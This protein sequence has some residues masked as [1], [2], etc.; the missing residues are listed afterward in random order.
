[1]IGFRRPK[2]AG[3]SL[4]MAPLIDVVFQLLIF[5]MLTSAFT[6]P[7]IKLDLPKATTKDAKENENISIVID[8]QGKITLNNTAVS[9]EN[10]GSSMSSMLSSAPNKAVHLQGDA[11]MP[12]E[13]FVKVMDIARKAG[14]KQIHIVHSESTQS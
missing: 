10:L 7:T 3:L 2:K 8:R 12:Y 6:H 13:L 9:F 5:F 14:A 11:Q 4:D 1:M